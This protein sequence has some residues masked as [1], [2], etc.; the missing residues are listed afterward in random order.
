M[1]RD[2]DDPQLLFRP[3]TGDWYVASN[4]RWYEPASDADLDALIALLPL[5]V[6][7]EQLLASIGSSG[8]FVRV[9]DEKSGPTLE[10]LTSFGELARRVT[11]RVP[12]VNQG[13]AEWESGSH[14]DGWVETFAT[15]RLDGVRRCTVTAFLPS[16]GDGSDLSSKQVAVQ[17]TQGRRTTVDIHQLRRGEPTRIEVFRSRHLARGVIVTL[18]T[19][20]PEPADDDRALGFVG[21]GIEALV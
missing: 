7:D 6:V 4:D 17:T 3:G 5:E 13:V 18:Q 10:F 20:V 8:G 16:I 11:N 14:P 21:V 12:G 15:L 19:S 1:L 2:P 9:V